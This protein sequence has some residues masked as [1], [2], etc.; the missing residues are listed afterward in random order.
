MKIIREQHPNCT[1]R[2]GE[3]KQ[4]YM[5]TL[6]TQ[7]KSHYVEKIAAITRIELYR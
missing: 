6:D 3:N 4:K 5:E 2:K 1:R 7:S